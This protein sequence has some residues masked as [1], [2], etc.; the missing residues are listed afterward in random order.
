MPSPNSNFINSSGV[1]NSL[2]MI[3]HYLCDNND[4]SKEKENRLQNIKILEQQNEK[5]FDKRMKQEITEEE[6]TEFKNKIDGKIENE[7][8]KTKEIKKLEESIK[9]WF[10]SK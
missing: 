5:L 1:T 10:H 2:L 3:C 4:Y 6:F 8:K 7:T 9:S